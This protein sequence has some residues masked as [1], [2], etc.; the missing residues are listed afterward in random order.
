MGI[1]LGS[2]CK[3]FVEMPE[4]EKVSKFGNSLGGSHSYNI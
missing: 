4:R 2:A 3:V 1:K